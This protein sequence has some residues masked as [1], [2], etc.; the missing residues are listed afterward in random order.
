MAGLFGK[1]LSILSGATEHAVSEG[2][3]APEN[4]WPRRTIPLIYSL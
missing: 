4:I 2:L 1:I 3:R